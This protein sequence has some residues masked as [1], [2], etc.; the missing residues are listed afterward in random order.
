MFWW[1]NAIASCAWTAIWS[2]ADIPLF[3]LTSACR[4][5]P[6]REL[7]PTLFQHADGGDV[8]LGDVCMELPCRNRRDERGN[9]T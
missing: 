5:L 4:R 8:G 1:A 7:K 2:F 3:C 9:G 6:S